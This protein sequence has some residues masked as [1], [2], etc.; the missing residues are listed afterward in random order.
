MKP[1]EILVDIVVA[2]FFFVKLGAIMAFVNTDI[3]SLMVSLLE[4][5]SSGWGS[6]RH[7]GLMD[8]FARTQT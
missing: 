8:Q 6:N 4:S 5:G 1:E 3:T 7:S 2:I